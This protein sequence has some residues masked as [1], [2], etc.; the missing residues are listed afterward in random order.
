MSAEIAVLDEIYGR[1]WAISVNFPDTGPRMAS[2][3]TVIGRIKGEAVKRGLTSQEI[4][5][6]AEEI[7]N[8]RQYLSEIMSDYPET[9][10]EFMPQIKAISY[11]LEPVSK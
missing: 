11:L 1:C 7:A 8:L 2:A 3:R 5:E 6:L 9:K 4:D 10:G